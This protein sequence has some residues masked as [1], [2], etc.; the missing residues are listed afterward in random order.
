M[1]KY[2]H[3]PHNDFE[4]LLNKM[5]G[6]AVMR[7]YIRNEYELKPVPKAVE[8][9]L[10]RVGTFSVSATTE[11]FVVAD[12]FVVNTD[13]TEEVKIAWVGNNLKNWFFKTVEKSTPS[14]VLLIQKLAKASVDGPIITELGGVLKAQTSLG[15]MFA[16]MKK[17]GKGEKG[18]LLTNGWATI[19]YIPQLVTKLEG[20]AFSYVKRDSTTVTEQVSN[21]SYLFEMDSQWYVLRAVRCGWGGG[22]WGCDAYSVVGPN[23]WDGGDRVVSRNSATV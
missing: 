7:G 4:A 8:K 14:G 5:G 17:Q 19:F 18:D 9:L 22:G 1:S 16:L 13:D 2:G 21:P 15:E 12:K 23:G 6:E 10:L 11:K 20:N 3:I